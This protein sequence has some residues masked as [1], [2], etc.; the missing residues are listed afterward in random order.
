MYAESLDARKAAAAAMSSA[1]PSLF[2]RVFC[3]ISVLC[4]QKYVKLKHQKG[5]QFS[6]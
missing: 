1:A 2:S 3:P 6:Y 5:F 4:V